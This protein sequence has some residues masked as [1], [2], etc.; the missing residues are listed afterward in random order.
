MSK[1]VKPPRITEKQFM[2]SV[3]EMASALGWRF[4][5]EANSFGSKPG[6]PDLALFHP[7]H[8]A[9]YLELKTGNYGL[10]GPQQEWIDWLT[11]CRQIAYVVRPDD[12][13]VIEAMLRG[14][15]IFRE[16]VPA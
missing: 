7:D 14:N 8:G 15:M 16:D 12:M 1:H 10:T 11:H 9:L 2:R 13:D 5:H 6:F 4:H 3:T